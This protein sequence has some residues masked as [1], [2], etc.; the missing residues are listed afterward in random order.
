MV[1]KE[2]VKR[3]AVLAISANHHNGDP[4]IAISESNLL[5]AYQQVQVMREIKAEGAQ[6][7]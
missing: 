7:L 5:L 6:I 2:V 3:A 1:L 4:N